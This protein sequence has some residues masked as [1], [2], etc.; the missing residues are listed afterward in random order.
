MIRRPPRSTLFSLHDA[1]P[2]SPRNE[3]EENEEEEEKED[4]GMR[5]TTTTKEKRTKASTRRTASA[6]SKKKTAAVT[7]SNGKSFARTI[8]TKAELKPFEKWLPKD[9]EIELDTL[10]KALREDKETLYRGNEKKEEGTLEERKDDE[11]EN[12]KIGRA[13]V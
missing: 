11:N 3:E 9:G 8:L 4:G 13:H 1:L 2:I 7:Y 10:V 12:E 6:S 5:R